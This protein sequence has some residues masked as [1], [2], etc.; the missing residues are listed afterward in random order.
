MESDALPRTT[1]SETSVKRRPSGITVTRR[2][3]PTPSAKPGD[4]C[5]I[6]LYPEGQD[7][8]RRI[9]LRSAAL[10]LGRAAAADLRLDDEHASRRHARLERRNEC[11]G[12]VDL[13]SKN[14]TFVN[15]E[16]VSDTLLT[17]GDL[18][19]VGATI[20]KFLTGASVELAYHKELYRLTV[21][22]A[23]TRAYN[24]RYF[25]EQLARAAALAA[26]GGRPLS[27]AVLDLDRFKAVNDTY[28]HGCGDLVLREMVGR[29]LRRIRGSDLL[30]RIGGEEFAL[31]LPDTEH[32]QALLVAERVR[33]AIGESPFV[34][35]GEAI[36]VTVSIGVAATTTGESGEALLKRAD[37][38]LYRAKRTGRDRVV[39]EGDPTDEER[40]G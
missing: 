29:V 1:P 31:L 39:G 3:P 36:I 25:D 27:L 5:L 32:T 15:G 20:L 38:H 13:D 9:D 11:W 33:L 37:E 35:E 24:K 34:F 23:H 28:G 8:G 19:V 30:A 17:D 2:G 14:G 12:I 7:L 21:V 6:V 16:R 10:E 18:V 26:R 22:D 4:A 40:G